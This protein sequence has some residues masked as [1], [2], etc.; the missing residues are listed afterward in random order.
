MHVAIWNVSHIDNHF[1]FY[2][3][4]S[5]RQS[6]D[7]TTTT[8][9]AQPKEPIS[10]HHKHPNTTLTTIEPI[11]WGTVTPDTVIKR[12]DVRIRHSCPMVCA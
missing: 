9:S 8:Q 7:V 6:F 3:Y 2:T 12:K 5:Y 10:Q 4:L 1:I 11:L